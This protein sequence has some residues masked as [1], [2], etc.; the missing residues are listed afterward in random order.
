LVNLFSFAVLLSLFAVHCTPFTVRRSLFCVQQGL[1]CDCVA[2]E[3]IIGTFSALQQLDQIGTK[4]LGGLIPYPN[5][6]SFCGRKT[7][8][9]KIYQRP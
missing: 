5:D 8:K 3:G 9:E 1:F 4:H 2:E 7:N 6:S